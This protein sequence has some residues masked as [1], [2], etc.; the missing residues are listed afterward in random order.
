MTPWLSTLEDLQTLASRQLFFVGGAPR[1]GTTWV[2]E[3]LDG[4]P[5][6][7]CRGEGLFPHE[8]ARPIDMLVEYRR[9]VLGTK[10]ATTFKD[11]EG[12]PLPGRD[13]AD[14]LLGTAILLAL[15][16]QCAGQAY[17]AVGEKSPENTFL[18][19]R[20]KALFPAAKFIG[21][22]R[23]PRDS[24]SSAWH[25]WAKTQPGS[26]APGAKMAFVEA[27]LP[28]IEEGLQ[29]FAAYTDE[30]RQDVRIFTYESL[31][32]MPGPIVAGLFRFLDVSDD[33]AIVDACVQG[34]SFASLTGGRPAG[35]VED[36][37]FLRKGVAGEWESTLPADAAALVVDRLSWAYDWF[38][39][40]S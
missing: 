26:D 39:W 14:A 33:P 8:L 35:V 5:D 32:Q 18:F 22:A 13:D 15:R 20:V 12:Y 23:D 34:A 9:T 37:A 38:A 21:I 25:F 19:P 29:R 30:Y 31:L 36:G 3:L 2:Q 4:H 24:L 28:A 7:S 6:V 40:P 17:L 27:S 10:N 11:F 16:Q 1:S